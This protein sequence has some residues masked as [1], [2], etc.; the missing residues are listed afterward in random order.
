MI[1]LKTRPES[2]DIDPA[3]SAVIVVDM[4]NAF[5]SK[6]GM[7]DIAGVDISSAALVTQKIAAVLDGARA[8][9]IPVVHLQMGYKPDQSNSGGP[10]SPNWHKE[11]AMTLMNHRPEL[12]GK[13]LT[14]GT[15]DFEVVDEL[16]PHLNDLVVVKTRYS[17]FAGTP[18]DSILRTRGLRYLFFAGIATNVCVEST[19]RDAYFLDYWPILLS[20]GA[21]P[22]GPPAAHDATIYNVENFFGWTLKTDDFLAALNPSKGRS[23]P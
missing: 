19:L 20:D 16:K 17:G 10:N 21:M 7:L 1:T 6:G 22:A 5:A 8:S 15:W 9:G 23:T 3:K 4:Q 18:L 2:L 13:L 11:L 14:E 12:K